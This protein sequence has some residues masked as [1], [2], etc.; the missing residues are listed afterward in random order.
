MQLTPEQVN[1]FIAKAVLESQIGQ[2]VKESVTRSI[3]ELNK[4]YQNP[5]DAVIRRQVEALIDAEVQTHYKPILEASIKE[6]MAR[7]MTSEIV[8][9]IIEAGMEKLRS[10][11]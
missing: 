4:S 8:E 11:Y 10:R 5:F 2:V 9:K 6:A 3:Q 7:Y 1:E